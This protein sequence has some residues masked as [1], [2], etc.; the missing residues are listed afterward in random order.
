MELAHR[1]V[2][3]VNV[4]VNESSVCRLADFGLSRCIGSDSSQVSSGGEDDEIEPCEHSK[5]SG[6]SALPVHL[7]LM[8]HGPQHHHNW[9]PLP[10]AVMPTHPDHSLLGS[11]PYGVPELLLPHV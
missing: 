7:S 8:H 4:L 2:K 5:R 3:L 10:T 6:T 9:S 1:D 11:L